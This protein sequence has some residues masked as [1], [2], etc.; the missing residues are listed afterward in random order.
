MTK[1]EIELI[2]LW[3]STANADVKKRIADLPKNE[4][5]NT[6]LAHY[7]AAP[8]NEG[9]S[10]AELPTVSPGKVSQTDRQKAE[11]QGVVITPITPDQ[12]FLALD[13]V[14]TPHFGDAQMALLLPL[15]E[16][17]VWL[18]LSATQ[19]TGK[20]LLQIAQFKNLTRLSL[21]NTRITDAG[22]S[23]LRNLPALQHLNLYATS[24]TDQ[25]LKTL[26]SCKKLKTLYLWQ[27]RVTPDGVAGL[28]ILAFMVSCLIGKFDKLATLLMAPLY[29]FLMIL[30]VHIPRAAT[31]KTTY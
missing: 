16:H 1:A 30:L 9:G 19:V 12:S 26:E 22:L 31:N 13:R 29:V 8:T 10:E 21:D 25:G 6:W 11:N 7:R 24:V 4:K 2:D 15:K 14:N 17:I 18:D 28:C 5:V 20:S 23:Q 27:T 3:I